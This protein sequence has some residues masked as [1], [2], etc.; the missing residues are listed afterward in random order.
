M[1]ALSK[2]RSR[3][4]ERLDVARFTLEL[5][6]EAEADSFA[7]GPR[8]GI[9]GIACLFEAGFSL[10]GGSRGHSRASGQMPFES[11]RLPR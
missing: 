4:L 2:R 9:S 10:D 11:S 7:G 5:D 6:A 8:Q 3:N 1:G